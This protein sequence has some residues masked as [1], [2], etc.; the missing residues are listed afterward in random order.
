VTRIGYVES[1]TETVA[2]DRFHR[3]RSASVH[4]CIGG[5]SPVGMDM[6]RECR[7]VKRSV[8]FQTLLIS[9]GLEMDLA[10]SAWLWSLRSLGA[11][12]DLNLKKNLGLNIYAGRYDV[13]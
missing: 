8:Y 3:T 11:V 4:R 12:K 1:G 2:V 6:P 7:L 13:V 9:I 10:G 5:C